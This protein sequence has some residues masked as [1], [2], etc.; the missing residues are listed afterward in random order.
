[1][2]LFGLFYRS[3][4]DL[5]VQNVRNGSGPV[6]YPFSVLSMMQLE[7]DW[8]NSAILCVKL[9][10]IGFILWYVVRLVVTV[11]NRRDEY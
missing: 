4:Y 6:F 9:T 5:M 1:M 11:T 2:Y 8:V 3:L 7:C 10:V